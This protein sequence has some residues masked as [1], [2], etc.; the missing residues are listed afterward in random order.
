MP[1]S[2]L[3]QNSA[4]DSA[5]IEGLTKAFENVCR[6][7]KLT[8]KNPMRELVARK[9]IDF[10]ER[11]S[12]DPELIRAFVLTEIQQIYKHSRGSPKEPARPPDADAA[13]A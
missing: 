11:G 6:E 5:E 3:L 9:I 8:R 12:R 4:F 10:A 13:S 2:R 7:L 1:I